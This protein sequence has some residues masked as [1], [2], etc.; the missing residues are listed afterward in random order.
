MDN[1]HTA[2]SLAYDMFD[3][4]EPS[5]GMASPEYV[6]YTLRQIQLLYAPVYPAKN[7]TGPGARIHVKMGLSGPR[8]GWNKH[9][10]REKRSELD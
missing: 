3:E 2:T 5:P 9:I 6:V 10:L 1:D 7:S 4:R 8:I